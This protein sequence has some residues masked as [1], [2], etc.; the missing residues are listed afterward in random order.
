LLSVGRLWCDDCCRRTV[1][2]AAATS[3]G[4]AA[5]V[6]KLCG[7]LAAIMAA[8]TRVADTADDAEDFIAAP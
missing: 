8:G 7:Q 6:G 2:A 5:V 1:D 4:G 3:A